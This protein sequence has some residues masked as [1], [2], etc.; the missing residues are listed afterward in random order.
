MAVLIFEKLEEVENLKQVSSKY[1]QD[2][3]LSNDYNKIVQI[4]DQYHAKYS[5]DLSGMT[6]NNKSLS[7]LKDELTNS[8][9]A[10]YE[11]VSQD[12]SISEWK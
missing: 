5:R 11:K 3:K 1:T 2:Y 6:S 8:I 12:D 7:Y 10:L 4:V 9:S